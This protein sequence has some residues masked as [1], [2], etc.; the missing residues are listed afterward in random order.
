MEVAVDAPEP[1]QLAHV[2][3]VDPADLP[4]VGRAAHVAGRPRPQPGGE[5]LGSDH[6][7]LEL[8]DQVTGGRREARRARRGAQHLEPRPG[9]DALQDP[10]ALQR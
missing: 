9:D 6:R 3:A 4:R 7:A 10:L 5:A 1:V 8:G 2:V